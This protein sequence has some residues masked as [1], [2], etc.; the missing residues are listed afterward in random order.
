MILNAGNILLIGL[1][2]YLLVSLSEKQ[3]SVSEYPLYFSFWE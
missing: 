2:Y 3:V 1:S